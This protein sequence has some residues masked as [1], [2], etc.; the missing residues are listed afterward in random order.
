MKLPFGKKHAEIA[1]SFASSAVGFGGAGFLTLLYFTD[2]K[3]VLQYVPF[4]GSKF[5]KPE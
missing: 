3:V 4:Y 1:T 5:D 2:W